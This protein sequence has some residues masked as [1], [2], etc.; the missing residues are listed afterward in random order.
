V[1]AFDTGIRL[2][3]GYTQSSSDNFDFIYEDVALNPEMEVI[4]DVPI[5][6]G[7][8]SYYLPSEQ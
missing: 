6:V 1:I 3:I 5:H 2:E 7:F 4:L 8:F